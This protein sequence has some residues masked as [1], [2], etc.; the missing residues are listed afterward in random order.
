MI[1]M[2]AAGLLVFLFTKEKTVDHVAKLIS[3]LAEKLDPLALIA[4]L[5]LCLSGLALYVALKVVEIVS[6][7]QR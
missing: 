6:G 7:K 1:G 4:I 3:F 2:L 5:A